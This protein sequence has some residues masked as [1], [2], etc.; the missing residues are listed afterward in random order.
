MKEGHWYENWWKCTCPSGQPQRPFKYNYCQSL[1][2]NSGCN[3]EKR[4]PL[5]Y[6]DTWNCLV[7]RQYLN[8]GYLVKVKIKFVPGH[9]FVMSRH[10][11]KIMAYEL[12]WRILVVMLITVIKIHN[13]RF[14][15]F[16]WCTCY[17][18][19][20]LTSNFSN[21]WVIS[22]AHGS[23]VNK[24]LI[25]I[26]CISFC[27]VFDRYPS[28]RVSK[29]PT[30]TRREVPRVITNGKRAIVDHSYRKDKLWHQIHT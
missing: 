12:H 13:I 29:T 4:A 5:H 14:S 27:Q 25:W 20:K 19:N 11:A 26:L 17:T 3:F 24:F 23:V 2:S 15:E 30:P 8:Q 9:G 28:Y 18:T 7:S 22:L 16:V 6:Q 10:L 1:G 21:T